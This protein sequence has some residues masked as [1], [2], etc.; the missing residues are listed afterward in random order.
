MTV[1]LVSCGHDAAL[2]GGGEVPEP[3]FSTPISFAAQE[4]EEQD[5]TRA[6][7][8]PGGRP[9]TRAVGLQTKT[10]FF[11]VYGFKNMACDDNANADP[12]D[13][14]Y[15]DCKEVFPGYYVNWV[16]N[17]AG[18]STTNTAGWEY[19]DQQ[20]LGQTEQTIKYWDWNAKAYRFFGV[21]GASGTNMVEATLKTYPTYVAYELTY[22]ADATHPTQEE[23][24]P[25]YSHLWFSNGT[26]PDRLFG[27]P[28]QL[29]FIKPLSTVRFKF[30]FEDP[31]LAKE[32]EL[33]EK[34][35]HP[36]DNNTIKRSGKVTITYPLTGTGVRETFHVTAEAG[37]IPAFTQDYYEAVSRNDGGTVISPY[38]NANADVTDIG[39]VYTVL[40]AIGQGTYTLSVNVGGDPKSTIVPEEFM[41]WLPGYSYTYIFKV[42]VDKSVSIDAVQSAFTQW[43]YH[44][45]DHTVYNW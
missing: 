32:T 34:R 16:A 3:E 11:K 40:P 17:T 8:A 43:E 10:T 45:A 30:I 38:L 20:P 27:D 41:D 37:G 25:Y 33:R 22:E 13:D 19:V 6:E 24:V 42:H 7:A 2:E 26:G 39:I 35:F 1:L 18:T 15:S 31:D 14:S 44:D 28:V 23:K 4:Q 9:V 5:I 12:A 36:T 29:E 21:A